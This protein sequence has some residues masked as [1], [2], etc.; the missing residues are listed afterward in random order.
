MFFKK[1]LLHNRVKRSLVLQKFGVVV[2]KVL[3]ETKRVIFPED[4]VTL[5]R[6]V[7]LEP[8]D[9]VQTILLTILRVFN[10]CKVMR[11]N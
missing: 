7:L 5:C 9:M 6:D 11:S 8:A 1:N 10:T 2:I 3:V 4:T